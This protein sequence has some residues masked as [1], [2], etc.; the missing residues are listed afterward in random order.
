MKSSKHSI[1]T[2]GALG[3]IAVAAVAAFTGSGNAAQQVA[4]SPQTPPTVA[5]TPEE[6]K[7]LTATP[8]TWNG[9]MPITFSYQ[10]RRCDTDGGSCSDI[11]A[12]DDRTYRLRQVDVGDTL[13]VRVTARNADGQSSASSVPTAVIRDAPAP[14]PPPPPVTGCALNAPLQVGRLA[15]PE[16][17]TIDGQQIFPSP[18][19]RSTGSITVRF[20][21]SC[22]GKAVQ[23]A[24]V[25]VT[26]TPYNQFTIPNEQP[27]G[28]DGW[29][30]LRLNRLS[31]YPA[32][33]R[34]QLLVLFVRAR[35][36]GENPLGGIST[37]R[38]VSFTVDLNR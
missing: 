32:T 23:G 37:R 14:P 10:W 31:G 8:G 24:L 18:V 6:G 35:K 16:R 17:L 22:R 29:A 5:G 38:L 3:A 13:R 4:P 1:A 9:S 25:Y 12:A 33:P 20:H 36:P 19:G 11:G 26:A 27:T 7:T 15:A 30:E 2:T 21:V 34:Q 28:S